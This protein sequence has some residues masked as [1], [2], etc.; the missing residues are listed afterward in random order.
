VIGAM[1]R[2][3]YPVARNYVARVTIMEGRL[4]R[5]DHRFKC[6]FVGSSLFT[7]ALIRRMYEESPAVIAK[8]RVWIPAVRKLILE[9]WDSIDLCVAVLPTRCEAALEG[10]SDY[11]TTEG[12]RQVID[13][14]GSWDDVKGR[15]SKKKRQITNT[16]AERYGLGYRISSDP[17]DFDY[18]YYRMFV[19]HIRKRFGALSDIDS[20]EDM[21]KFFG[22]GRLVLVTK[23]EKV[24]AG[25]LS[26]VEDGALVFRRTGV[27]D[28]DES[29]V[30]GGAQTA[31]Y[32]FQ[33]KY[34]NEHHLHSVDTML[35]DPFL[36]D[37]VYRHKREWG[38]AV[39]PD[40]EAI[41]GV[42]FCKARPCDSVAR[43]F[44]SN[45]LVFYSNGGLSGLIGVP[46]ATDVTAPAISDLTH[47]YRSR[48]LAGFTVVTRT[49][50]FRVS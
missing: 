47:R 35:S 13:T 32:Y 36:N 3:L 18:F 6:L 30:D 15:F 41:R 10:L 43:F 4:K 1:K 17:E 50:T 9:K 14:S 12:V 37:G 16:F 19:P 21:K 46:D 31:L 2:M 8:S 24:V 44:E 22:K 27:L 29:L 38:A 7:D 40:V 49:E 33:L 25:A 34:A 20:Y 23:N 45:P 39:L 42:Y 26:L 48:G 5:T 28:G 11:K